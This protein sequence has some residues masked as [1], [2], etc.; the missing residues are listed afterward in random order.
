MST[1]LSHQWVDNG[2]DYKAA[3]LFPHFLLLR[4]YFPGTWRSE[5]ASLCRSIHPKK[6]Y[7]D[8]PADTAEKRR[9][10]A[11]FHAFKYM[12]G[13]YDWGQEPFPECYGFEKP[14]NEEEHADLV[15]RF[16]E[17]VYPLLW[18]TLWDSKK[19]KLGV[20]LVRKIKEGI[21]SMEGGGFVDL[22]EDMKDPYGNG[23][24]FEFPTGMQLPTGHGSNDVMRPLDAVAFLMCY[25]YAPSVEIGE[26][27][28]HDALKDA[29]HATFGGR[30]T[31]IW[32][33]NRAK[34]SGKI[35]PDVAPVSKK[36]KTNSIYLYA[37]LVQQLCGTSGDTTISKEVRK[38]LK[39]IG[40]LDPKLLTHAFEKLPT[41]K[42]HVESI[43]TAPSPKV[44][45]E[46]PDYQDQD[47][48]VD[49]EPPTARPK[50]LD[51]DE[52]VD[53]TQDPPIIDE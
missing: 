2:R 26:D 51:D 16:K 45:Q 5:Y 40:L 50:L 23:L 47:E 25:D 22:E 17:A 39:E 42:R 30:H 1:D 20:R 32:E 29:M 4:T 24:R 8:D 21:D 49:E 6:Y 41:K 52:I 15:I 34:T 53:E 10:R 18:Y 13:L 3:V 38:K 12:L 35:R 33:L 28:E 11:A 31:R 48:D 43:S 36:N 37:K 14:K 46:M 7:E 44:Y 19:E 9:H 27:G